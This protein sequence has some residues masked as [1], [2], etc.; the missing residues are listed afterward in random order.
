MDEPPAIRPVAPAYVAPSRNLGCY[1]GVLGEGIVSHPEFAN[2]PTPGAFTEYFAKGFRIGGV[3]GCDVLFETG[4]FLG[5]DLTGAFGKLEGR[6]N[7][8]GLV[9]DVPFES[10]ARVRAGYMFSRNVGVYAA[11]G[12]TVDHLKT[13][14]AIGVSHTENAWG[15]QL[16]V[17]VEHH[18]A[19]NWR[20]RGEYA[21]TYPGWTTVPMTGFPL[22]RMNPTS[23][24]V[25]LG[26]IYG[27]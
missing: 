24:S 27:F 6:H 23:H 20:T 26:V 8:T 5:V 15:G 21:Y 14:D 25:R 3:I 2:V 16:A 4:A 9:G 1:A 12:F 18:F 11:G 13:T 22:V 10:A 7:L 19:P 17:G